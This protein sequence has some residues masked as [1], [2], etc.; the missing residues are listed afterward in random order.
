MALIGHPVVNDKQYTYGFATQMLRT[1][2]TAQGGGQGSQG[3]TEECIEAEC[4]ADAEAC[5]PDEASDSCS[6]SSD[7]SQ[8]GLARDM[9][10]CI[11]RLLHN[12]WALIIRLACY[13]VALGRY[14]CTMALGCRV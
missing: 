9:L 14:R 12:H 6:R 4:D 11:R 5:T 3:A 10:G 2:S 13:A 7:S 1:G 8:V